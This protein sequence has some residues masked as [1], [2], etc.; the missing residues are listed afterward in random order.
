MPS[1]VW[2]MISVLYHRSSKASHR[3]IYSDF[4]LWAAPELP[5]RNIPMCFS[6]HVFDLCKRSR[7]FFDECPYCHGKRQKKFGK[8]HGRQRWACGHRG[9]QGIYPLA[10]SSA[11]TWDTSAAAFLDAKKQRRTRRTGGLRNSQSGQLPLCPGQAE[12]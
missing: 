12:V 11:T 9:F 6:D 8:E 5:E 2:G 3:M 4:P 10:P 1:F 7:T